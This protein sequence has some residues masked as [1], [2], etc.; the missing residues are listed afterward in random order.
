M[1]CCFEKHRK[2]LN[3]CLADVLEIVKVVVVVGKVVQI[4]RRVADVTVGSVRTA[5]SRKAAPKKAMAA[6]VVE[7]VRRIHVDVWYVD[8]NIVY[9]PVVNFIIL[10][11]FKKETRC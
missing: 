8:N 9:Q 7:V 11:T 3:R 1:K 2:N 4:V 5:K 6:V 10:P